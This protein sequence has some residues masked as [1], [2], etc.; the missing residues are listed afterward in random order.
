MLLH[1]EVLLHGIAIGIATVFFLNHWFAR[2][3]AAFSWTVAGFCL[4][5]TAYLV[6]GLPDSPLLPVLLRMAL[7]LAAVTTPWF[8]WL[9]TQ[10]LFID[11]FKI[12]LLHL[13]GLGLILLGAIAHASLVIAHA[14]TWWLP[15]SNAGHR[16]IALA[17]IFHALSIIWKSGAIE[18]VEAR[19][20]LRGVLLF[21]AGVMV[22]L[23]V[24]A[25][26][27]YLPSPERPVVVRLTEVA[28]ITLLMLS[29]SPLMFR[30]D[31]VLL[32]APT[33]L[34]SATSQQ[35]QKP[36]LDGEDEIA[37]N[38]LKK[39]MQQDE[40]W[41]ETGLSIGTLALRIG[42]P[43]YRLRRLINSQLGYRNFNSFLND[44]RLPA[45]ATALSDPAHARTP[46]LTLALELGYG[47]IGPF[48]RAFRDRYDMTPTDY[49]RHKL[50][51]AA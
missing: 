19:V 11:G 42:L 51:T 24:L 12:R 14:S 33:K 2:P 28:L 27:F 44:Q 26:I 29:L 43:E 41:R 15:F 13:A 35:S 34:V 32:P 31:E 18:L 4:G 16:L 36:E 7:G 9:F 17:F 20:R 47:S 1:F 45:A 39:L 6:W 5:L 38:R 30:I 40:I 49:R 8:F 10:Q 21:G 48:N 3:F 22:A 46:I 37:L 50:G 25:A 23:I